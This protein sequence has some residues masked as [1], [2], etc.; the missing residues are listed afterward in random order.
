MI[1][2]KNISI[3]QFCRN[4]CVSLKWFINY[5]KERKYIYIQYYGKGKERH[6]NIAFP[7]YD[8]EEG[9]GLFEMNR[10]PSPFNKNKNNINIQMTPK[11]QECFIE[12]LKKEGM[13]N[14]DIKYQRVI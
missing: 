8:T 1:E 13:I 14:G 9:N 7:K 4:N 6:K 12:L 3:L 11:G 2:N 5:L 10:K